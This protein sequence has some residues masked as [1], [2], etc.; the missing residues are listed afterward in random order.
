MSFSVMFT[1]AAS[2]LQSLTGD[3][4]KWVVE[5]G[6]AAKRAS[7]E[8]IAVL[9][10]VN[11]AGHCVMTMVHRVWSPAVSPHTL[12]AV[13]SGDSKVLGRSEEEKK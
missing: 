3:C 6:H 12:R 8:L 11:G 5:C 1:S 2:H 13:V 10:G 4:R 9:P 7:G